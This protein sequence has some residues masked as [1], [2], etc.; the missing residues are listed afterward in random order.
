MPI[1]AVVPSF[2][3]RWPDAAAMIGSHFAHEVPEAILTIDVLV[4]V[5]IEGEPAGFA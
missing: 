3:D 2:P 4:K 5:E 1:R